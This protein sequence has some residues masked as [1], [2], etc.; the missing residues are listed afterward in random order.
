MFLCVFVCEVGEI[1]GG[2]GVRGI[3][4]HCG[5]CVRDIGNV[6]DSLH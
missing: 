3:M 5:S 6:D 4:E 2:G 1:G